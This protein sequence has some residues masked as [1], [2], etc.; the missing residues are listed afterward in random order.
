MLA[1]KFTLTHT[2]AKKALNFSPYITIGLFINVDVLSL[3][4][5]LIRLMPKTKMPSS[6]LG[7]CELLFAVPYQCVCLTS[8][9]GF[10]ISLKCLLFN[11]KNKGRE[12]SIFG[13]NDGFASFHMVLLPRL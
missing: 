13:M 9:F 6:Y 1:N 11:V 2:L 7:L 12:N 8:Y 4:V 10:N 3:F 5:I